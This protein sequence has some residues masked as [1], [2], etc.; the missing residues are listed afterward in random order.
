[1][2]LKEAYK[3]IKKIGHKERSNKHIL[4]KI[5]RAIVNEALENDLLIVLGKLKGIRKNG[6]GRRFNR[7]PNNGFPYSRLSQFIEY[8]ARWLGILVLKIDER[9]ASKLYVIN[10][11]AKNLNRTILW[12]PKL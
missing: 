4:H 3:T 7:K 5:S 1:M 9:N 12:L 2:A 6:K 10:V 8:K 11:E